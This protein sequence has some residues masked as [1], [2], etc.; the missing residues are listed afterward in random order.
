ME[1]MAERDYKLFDNRDP[2]ITLI[3][4]GPGTGKSFCIEK[5]LGLGNIWGI[6]NIVKSCFMGVAAVNIDGQT[7]QKFFKF[8]AD[9]KKNNS[10]DESELEQLENKKEIAPLLPNSLIEFKKK[11][12]DIS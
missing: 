2:P 8:S 6:E 11:P 4:G 3:T 10:K 12:R 7:I 5:I 1:S 9:N